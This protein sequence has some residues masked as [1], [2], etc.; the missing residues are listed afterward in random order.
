MKDRSDRELVHLSQQGNQDAFNE[1]VQRHQEK[2]LN[3]VYRFSSHW[4]DAQDIA[5][6]TFLNAWKNISKF[7]GDSAFSTWLY[8]IAFNQSISFRREKGRHRAATIHAEDGE[9][10][11]DPGYD[12]DPA[13][14]IEATEK[15]RQVHQ[16][17]ALLEEEDRKIIVLKDLKDLS[18]DE[19]A[20][21]LEIPKGTVRSRLHRARLQ[22][23]EKW[24]NFS[25]T[26][27]REEAS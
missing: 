15:E 4:G 7:K 19:I 3:S 25:G 16:V 5:Q 26:S 27:S 20:S 9:K 22:V 11:I 24:T 12:A 17:L 1:L 6:R 23:K 18:Y 21:I 2:V 14:P 10:G 13:A 8:R